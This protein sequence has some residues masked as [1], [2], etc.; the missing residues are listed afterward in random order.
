MEDLEAAMDTL[1]GHNRRWRKEIDLLDEE[2]I[3]PYGKASELEQVLQIFLNNIAK[4]GLDKYAGWAVREGNTDATERER[5]SAR[6]FIDSIKSAEDI[7]DKARAVE[8]K[9]MPETMSAEKVDRNLA[10]W[11]TFAWDRRMMLELAND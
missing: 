8:Q 5:R 4:R 2:E 9:T 10:K 1:E 11:S 6:R 3:F 7:V